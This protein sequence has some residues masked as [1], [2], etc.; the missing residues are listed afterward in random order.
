MSTRELLRDSVLGGDP[1][2]D[3]SLFELFDPAQHVGPAG[4][5]GCTQLVEQLVHGRI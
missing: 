4:V 3:E 2:G 1:V 5:K